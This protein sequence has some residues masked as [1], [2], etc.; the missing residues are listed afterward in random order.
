VFGKN[1][2]ANLAIDKLHFTANHLTNYS[3]TPILGPLSFFRRKIVQHLIGRSALEFNAWCD[4]W[5]T[6]I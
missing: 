3:F 1:S 6:G 2:F 4:V 5:P